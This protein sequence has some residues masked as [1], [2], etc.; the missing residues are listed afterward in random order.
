M[1]L[2]DI[3]FLVLPGTL[4]PDP[5][6]CEQAAPQAPAASTDRPPLP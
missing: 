1:N 4:F 2:E 3:C 6:R 5:L